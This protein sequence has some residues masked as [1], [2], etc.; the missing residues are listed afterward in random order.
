MKINLGKLIHWTS[1]SCLTITLIIIGP[2]LTNAQNNNQGQLTGTIWQGAKVESVVKQS[3]PLVFTPQVGLPGFMDKYVFS[4]NSTAPIAKLMKAIFNYGIQTIGL[5]TLIVIIFGGFMWST[6]GGNGNKV[7][8]AKQWLFSGL[9]GLLLLMFSYLILRTINIDLVNFKT[10]DIAAITKLNLIVAEKSN[11]E[12]VAG[13]Q[14]FLDGVYAETFGDNPNNEA[15]CIFYNLNAGADALKV[16]SVAYSGMDGFRS[17]NNFCLDFA[18]GSGQHDSEGNSRNYTTNKTQTNT[19]REQFIILSK[20]DATN[21]VPNKPFR[22][23]EQ[24]D[25]TEQVEDLGLFIVIDAACWSISSYLSN[26]AMGLDNPNYCKKV[27]RNNNGW[28]CIKTIGSTK[29]WGYCDNNECKL[30]VS[31]GN[32][33]AHAYQCPNRKKVIGNSTVVS[34]Q[35]CGNGGLSGLTS[36]AATCDRTYHCECASADCFEECKRNLT[37]QTLLDN[38]CKGR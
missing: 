23:W 11:Q 18:R 32:T 22:T 14:G 24:F 2:I 36:N 29:N 26:T 35:Q 34:G 6:A 8:E 30:C 10:R 27:A 33:C 7:S 38:V 1:L 28:A 37:D 15:C 12:Q 5:I 19:G 3:A 9:G 21:R 31:Y 17:A 4:E 25:F 20:N 16:A 13:D